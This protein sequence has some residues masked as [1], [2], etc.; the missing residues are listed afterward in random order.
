MVSIEGFDSSQ[1][2]SAILAITESTFTGNYPGDNAPI[3]LL[4]TNSLS[5]TL[6][7]CII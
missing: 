1:D 2:V 6:S 7:K 5:T 3:L 4:N